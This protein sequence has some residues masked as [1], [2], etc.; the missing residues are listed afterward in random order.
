M[1]YQNVD[2][3]IIIINSNSLFHQDYF[4]CLLCEAGMLKRERVCQDHVQG[5]WHTTSV[6]NV[7]I[8]KK[9]EFAYLEKL[10]KIVFYLVLKIITR[11]SKLV[12]DTT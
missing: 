5:H 12:L 8:N 3:N 6:V 11:D 1:A 4:Q 10:M 9:I 7:G 2:N